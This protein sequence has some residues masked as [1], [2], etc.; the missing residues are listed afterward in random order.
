M[1]QDNELDQIFRNASSANLNEEIPSV[2]LSDINSRL[3]TLEKN[4]KRPVAFWWLIGVFSLSLFTWGA[5]LLFNSSNDKNMEAKTENIVKRKSVKTNTEPKLVAIQTKNKLANSNNN[6]TENELVNVLN[7]SSNNKNNV[8]EENNITISNRFKKIEPTQ[9]ILNTFSNLVSELIDNEQSSEKVIIESDKELSK[10]NADN[11]I[12]NEEAPIENK[13]VIVIDSVTIKDSVL[14]NQT[15][16]KT[17][18]VKEKKK[19]SIQKEIGFFTGVSGILSSFSISKELENNF[20]TTTLAEYRET[21]ERE[22]V[23]TTSWDFSLRMKWVI[24]GISVQTGFD[25]FQWGEQIKYN[26]NSISGINRYSYLNIPINLGYA[27]TWNKFGLNPFAGVLLGYGINRTGMYLQPDL[28]SIAE[29]ESKKYLAN[30]QVG[31]EFY[32]LS[33][34]QF[35]FSLI[36]IYRA[37]FKEVVYTAIIRNRYKSI[38]LQLG[39]SYNF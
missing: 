29:A 38:G 17:D 20:V 33:D 27:K 32:F 13:E 39:I 4:R 11:E 1:K 3:D 7:N 2:F 22:E 34:S 21:R 37:S 24:N 35:K 8:S 25:Y 30:Y 16:E 26:Y 18:L 6:S 19:F 23:S 10:S 36:P 31:C 9:S 5:S 12:K 15:N 14:T 28:N